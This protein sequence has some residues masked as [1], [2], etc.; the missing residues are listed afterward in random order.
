[1]LQLHAADSAKEDMAATEQA[2]KKEAA[3]MR[4]AMEKAQTEAK[5]A[6][7]AASK[8]RSGV[9]GLDGDGC[10]AKGMVAEVLVYLFYKEVCVLLLCCATL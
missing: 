1:L 5:S 3:A 7:V 9:S 10:R 4:R 2:A 8:N 6:A